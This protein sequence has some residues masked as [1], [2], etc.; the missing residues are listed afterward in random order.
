MALIETLLPVYLLVFVRI[1]SFIIAAPLFNQ[2]GMPNHFK[3]GFAAVMAFISFA[4][5][6]ITGKIPLDISFTVYALKE[7]A[8][9]LVLGYLLQMMFSVVRVAGGLMDLQMGLAMANVVDPATGAYVPITGRLKEILATL[10]FLSING[11]HLMIRGIISSY[12][13]IPVDSLIVDLH[14][15]A[16]GFFVIKAFSH[17]FFSA[18]MMAAPIVVSLFLVD[19]SLGIIAKTVPQF[20]IFVVGLP[21]KLLVSFLL[22]IVVMPGFFII[23]G[24]YISQMFHALAELIGILGG[25]TS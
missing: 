17:M 19:L 5:V 16:F 23:L 22:L 10:Y 24:N 20:N 7:T 21:I 2:R 6:P 25:G 18:F 3:I 11:H 1:A 14:S 8:I 13:S 15:D 4:Y 9:G 12:Q